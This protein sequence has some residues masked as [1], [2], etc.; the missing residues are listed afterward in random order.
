MKKKRSNTTPK[1]QGGCTGKGFVKGDPRINKNGRPKA[2]DYIRELAQKIGNEVEP[3]IKGKPNKLTNAEI[4][5][6]QLMMHDGAKFIE[7]AYGKVVQPLGGEVNMTM[8]FDYD[9][10]NGNGKN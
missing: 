5:L 4:V 9:V 3:I 8:R 6:R 7:I 1:Q 10:D 2:F